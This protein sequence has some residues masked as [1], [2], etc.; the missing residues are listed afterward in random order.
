M[1]RLKEREPTRK[2]MKRTATVK[3]GAD[4]AG[5]EEVVTQSKED[6]DSYHLVGKRSM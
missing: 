6:I 3:A 1:K 5:Q 2:D 4:T